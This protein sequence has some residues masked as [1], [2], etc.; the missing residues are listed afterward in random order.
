MTPLVKDNRQTP[1]GVLPKKVKQISVALI[2]GIV[3][4]SSVFSGENKQELKPKTE[5]APVRPTQSQMSAISQ[6]LERTRKESEDSRLRAEEERR[7]LEEQLAT[8]DRQQ[9]PPVT[10]APREDPLRQT[11]RERAARA[12]FASNVVFRSREVEVPSASVEATPQLVLRTERNCTE[13][14]PPGAEPSEEESGKFLPATVGK[15]FRVYEGTLVQ[16]KLVNRL[17]G[18]F[19]GPVKCEVIAPLTSVG[20]ETVLIPRKALFIGEA[21][22]VDSQ[23]QRRLA[24]TF[25][26]LLLPNGYSVDLK[27]AP[28]L[29]GAGETGL[30]DKV[31]NHYGQAFGAAG[32][33]GMLS[34]LALYGGRGGAFGFGSGVVSGTGNAATNV[35]NRYLNVLPTVTIREGHEVNVYVSNDL[36]LPGYTRG[37]G[38][39]RN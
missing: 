37:T 31:N 22:R 8:R 23:N 9:P 2:V 19:T 20:G 35:L 13:S 1:P 26:R 30:S 25:H 27:K 36:L 39:E 29:N 4:L 21:R 3:L 7:R 33:V 34:G 11:E 28:G 10:Q 12:R 6:M 16:T 15:L 17:D 38:A 18:Y 14:R 32:A 24:V 5:S